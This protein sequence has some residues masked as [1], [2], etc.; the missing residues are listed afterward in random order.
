MHIYTALLRNRRFAM[1]WGGATISTFGDGAAWVA[2][3]WTVLRMDGSAGGL[4]WLVFA[5]TAPVV[6]GGLVAGQLLDRFD[7]RRL[8]IIDN[9]VRGGVIAAVPILY[10]TGELRIGHL[11][12]A[13]AVYGLLKMFPL[14]GIPAL[15]PEL[16]EDDEL[17]AA[18]A[19][20][21]FS[22]L[23]GG[24][25][26]PAFAG[27][28]LALVAAPYVLAVDAASYLVFALALIAAGPIAG[29]AA[30][31]GDA[32]LRPAIT[33]A[34]AIPIILAT[35]VMFMLVNVGEGIVLV[36]M[37]LYAATVAH[38]GGGA[39]GLMLA[40]SSAAGLGGAAF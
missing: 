22:F 39:Y 37:P 30:H 34:L 16:V 20:E 38:A 19:M 35:T 1:V 17:D 27:V 8:L 12:G 6:I 9:L 15:I 14:A 2:L 18:N 25:A 28:L 23:L 33:V 32:K 36:L 40:A 3:S 21:S 29:G 4:G 26:G 11:Y 31:A 24:A 5:Y 7:R 13:A 10:A